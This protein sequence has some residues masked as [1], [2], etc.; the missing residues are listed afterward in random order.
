MPFGAGPQSPPNIP[1]PN[2]STDQPAPPPSP[3]KFD[4]K[5][6]GHTFRSF[7]SPIAFDGWDIDRTRDAISA[8]DQGIFLESSQLAINVTR[9]GPVFAAMGQALAPALALPKYIRGGN[10][11][12]AR[13]MARLIEAQ[14]APRAGLQP[15]PHFPIT[16]WGAMS[17]DLKQMGFAVLQH[18]Y[19]DED[20][21]GVRPIYTRRW[22][23]WATQYH[24]WRRT[25]QAL[26]T[27]GPVDI[28]SGDGKFTLVADDEEPH[29]GG[30]VRALGTEVLSG[31]LVQQARQQYI[32]RYGDPKLMGTLPAEIAISSP[33]GLATFAAMQTILGPDGVGL[34]PH[35]TTLEWAELSAKASAV[36]KDALESVWQ[37]IAAILLGSDGTMTSGT[38]G[39]YTSPS[40]AGVAR[41]LVDRMLKAEVR[42]V[43]QGHIAPFLTF[44]YAATIAETRG[45]V[46]PVLDIPFPD[47]DADNALMD[48]TSKF[49]AQIKADREAGI[50]VTQDHV[51]RL[52]QKFNVDS[53]QLASVAVGAQSFAYDQEN[54]VITI[55][56][57]R[58]ELGKPEDTTGRGDMTVPEYREYLAAKRAER[59]AVAEAEAESDAEYSDDEAQDGADGQEQSGTDEPLGEVRVKRPGQRTSEVAMTVRDA[60][61]GLVIEGVNPTRARLYVLKESGQRIEARA[62]LVVGESDRIVA[63]YRARKPKEATRKRPSDPSHPT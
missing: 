49:T 6:H 15:S 52:A 53:V 10:R 39:V 22:P 42:A 55:N 36:F 34:M 24:R 18:A 32:D 61:E 45:W 57:R 17:F 40:F 19:G 50:D 59:V 48:R 51:D 30:A 38:G 27:D 28:I 58:Q 20:V 1:P 47:P 26:T 31:V 29:F 62:G 54:G 14:I 44:N 11:G 63:Y 16:L 21:N 12:L 35:G 9:F 13:A 23:T 25:F 4:P 33:E 3:L 2:Y 7:A 37:Y 56:D 46:S 60:A 5:Y 8:H 41:R 43:N